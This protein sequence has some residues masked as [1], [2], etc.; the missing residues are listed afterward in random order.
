MLNSREIGAVRDFGRQIFDLIDEYKIPV[1]KMA[2]L[3]QV[4][5]GNMRLFRDGKRKPSANVQANAQK[6]FG[7][8]YTEDTS[9]LDRIAAA[10]IFRAL[11]R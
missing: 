5:S 9:G 4:D 1:L 11:K 2:K 3:L 7:I 10:G 6:Y 8:V